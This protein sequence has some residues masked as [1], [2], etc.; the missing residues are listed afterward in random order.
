MP[1]WCTIPA[2]VWKPQAA[3]QSK[4]AVSSLKVKI[5]LTATM[6]ALADVQALDVSPGQPDARTQ[7][8]L[9][10]LS[11]ALNTVHSNINSLVKIVDSSLNSADL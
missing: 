5:G 2:T 9:A 1:T 10:E 6:G 8:D 4:W 7:R 3:W 11:V